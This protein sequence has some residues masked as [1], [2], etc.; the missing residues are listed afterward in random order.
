EAEIHHWFD[1]FP[2]ANV[3]LPLG[4]STNQVMLDVDYYRPL[5]RRVSKL[6]LPPTRKVK[7]GGGMHYY[8]R[9]DGDI[10]VTRRYIQ[11]SFLHGD[12]CLA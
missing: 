1:R 4:R 6:N 8:F 10:P 3:M 11:G 7:S 5:S 12:T 9:Y 2:Q